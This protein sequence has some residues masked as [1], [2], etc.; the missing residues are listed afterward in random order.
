MT[1]AELITR[2]QELPQNMHVLVYSPYDDCWVGA[3][4]RTEIIAVKLPQN[5]QQPYDTYQVWDNA[6]E[7]DM[8]VL[9]DGESFVSAVSIW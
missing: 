6:H 2:L 9:N 3:D 5:E 4:V 8:I 7:T 1:V